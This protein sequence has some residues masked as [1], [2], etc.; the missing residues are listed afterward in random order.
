VDT[1][2]QDLRYALRILRKSP[3]FALVAVLTLALGAGANT[4]TFSA[5][6]AVLLRPLPFKDPDR[7][8]LIW[9][10]VPRLHRDQLL[11]SI[12]DYL[13]WQKQN[14]VFESLA[15]FTDLGLILT[16]SGES[17]HL[18]AFEV[19]AGLFPTL[20]AQPFIGRNFLGEEDRRGG[21]HVVIL[22][23]ALWKRRF[24][25]DRNIVGTSITLDGRS[26][27]VIGVMPPGFQFPIQAEPGELWIPLQQDEFPLM[28]ERNGREVMTLARLK[29]RIPLQ[30]AQAEMDAI[31]QR[32]ELQYPESNRDYGATVI[33]WHEQLV[34]KSRLGLLVLLGA[35]GFLLLIAC[36]NL[37]NLYAIRAMARRREMA[38]RIALG[39]S[40]L[41]LIRQLL[42]EMV[43]VA[44]AGSAVGILLTDASHQV[45]A[46][47]LPADIPRLNESG[48]D[49]RVLSFTGLISLLTVLLFGLAPA[50]RAS[51]ITLTDSLKETSRSSGGWRR[52]RTRQLLVAGEV[53][54][55]FVLLTGA[56]LLLRSLSLLLDVQPGFRPEL[57]LTISMDLAA[58]QYP[59]REQQRAFFE[60][61]LEKVQELPGVRSASAVFPLPLSSPVAFPISIEGRPAAAGE[62]QGAYFRAISP[63]YFL[64]MGIPLVRGRAFSPADRSGSAP[65]VI[66]NQTMAQ[67]FWPGGNPIGNRIT[68]VDPV[69]QNESTT[70]EVVGVVGDV[71]HAGL[72][73]PAGP[74]MYVPAAQAP[75]LWMSLVVRTTGDPALLANSVAAEVRALDP[76][77]PVGKI[78]TMDQILTRWSAPRRFQT[79]LLTSFAALALLLTAVGIW[80]VVSYSAAQRTH[81]MGIRMALG[82]RPGDVLGL[83]LGEGGRLVVA[84]VALGAAAAAGLTRL[85]QSLLFEVTPRDPATFLI[86]AC[87]VGVAALGACSVPA[88]RAMRVDP[89]E[90]LR[91]E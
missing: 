39:S 64:T 52:Q 11:V 4:A 87:V 72:D 58:P 88:R 15:A 63:G 8:V 28:W 34:K 12:L 5:V 89:I 50:L 2:W 53:A 35:V 79:I 40:R 31:A 70:R 57:I 30:Q 66:V 41:R 22:S 3:G 7:L 54:L 86:V 37:G 43:L 60:R 85:M 74:E 19:S 47:L 27:S 83:I 14:T 90:A 21:R 6:N 23:H 76:N 82:A 45:F 48:L 62:R 17:E 46:S 9:G 10:R 42:T 56:G 67:R 91:C 84:G 51:R 61:A 59:Q 1:L 49:W 16:G 18:N 80:G 69:H 13:D 68:I 71:R 32:L 81:E 77:I 78:Q 29:P 55:A 75:F 36:A 24:A 25:S 20:G 73:A 38:I 65:V 44:M 33:P 26:Y